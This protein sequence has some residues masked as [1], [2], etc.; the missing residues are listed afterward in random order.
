MQKRLT[1]RDCANLAKEY[2]GENNWCLLR[3]AHCP[4]LVKH[5][6]YKFDKKDIVC[7]ELAKL[8]EAIDTPDKTLRECDECGR[9]FKGIGRSKY[10][11]DICRS[12]AKKKSNRK[13]YS[14]QENRRKR[15]L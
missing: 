15:E 4:L 2:N 11:G 12:I 3:D 1:A 5:E 14:N 6:R 7:V 13:S 10:C 8:N 9:G